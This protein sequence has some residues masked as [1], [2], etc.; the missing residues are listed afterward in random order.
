MA[1][2]GYLFPAPLIHGKYFPRQILKEN[3]IHR[4]IISRDFETNLDKFIL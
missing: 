3:L 4:H 1:R 2:G